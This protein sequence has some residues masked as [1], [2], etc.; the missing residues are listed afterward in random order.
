MNTRMIIP[1]ILSAVVLSTPVLAASQQGNANQ[2]TMQKAAAQTSA[3]RCTVLEKE[4]DAA[5]KK[6]EKAAKAEDA[7]KLR[8]EGST[9]CAGGK[10]DEGVA[11][12]ET[13]MKELGV[14]VKY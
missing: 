7:K 5:I 9:L 8:T 4:F 13:A 12:L 14:K 2:P 11:K 10:P 6:H 3:E 1:A